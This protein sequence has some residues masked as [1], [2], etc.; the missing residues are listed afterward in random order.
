MMQL[1]NRVR[2]FAVLFVATLPHLKFRYQAKG[3]L[4]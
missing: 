3:P 1:Q 4:E 2:Y